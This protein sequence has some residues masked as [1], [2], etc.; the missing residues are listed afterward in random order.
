MLLTELIEYNKPPAHG[1]SFKKG[2]KDLIFQSNCIFNTPLI[3]N[4]LKRYTHA[5]PNLNKT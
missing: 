4:P 3:E 5:V 1:N 2:V